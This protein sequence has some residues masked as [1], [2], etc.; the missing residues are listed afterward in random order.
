MVGQVDV[1][2]DGWVEDVR[3]HG[4]AGQ[5]PRCYKEV[6]TLAACR[7]DG[8]GDEEGVGDVDDS[9]STAELGQ[10]A[11]YKRPGSFAQL[12]DSHEQDARALVGVVIG[13]EVAHDAVCHR[14]DR[15]ACEGSAGLSVRSHNVL[16]VA[17]TW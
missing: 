14:H 3:G 8:G 7:E 2:H 10:R 12:P 4:D 9:V 5:K 6:C 16:L 17:R 15:D 13:V 11:Y 1:T